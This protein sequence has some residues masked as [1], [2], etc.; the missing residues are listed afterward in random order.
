MN[1]KIKL[2]KIENKSKINNFYE[3]KNN[4][5]NSKVRILLD[6]SA[7]LSNT[8]VFEKDKEKN[9]KQKRS[10]INIDKKNVDSCPNLNECKKEKE[11]K[12]IFEVNKKITLSVGKEISIEIPSLYENIYQLSNYKY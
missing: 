1:K 9:E 10:D 12:K 3:N 4:F 11:E 5:E 2:S 6:Y 8:N 7:T